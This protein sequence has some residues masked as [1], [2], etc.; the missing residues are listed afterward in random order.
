MSSEAGAAEWGDD[1][2]AGLL[3]HRTGAVRGF[4]TEG[5]SLPVSN[6]I[7]FH[8]ASS[9][10]FDGFQSG[11]EC[12]ARNAVF[13]MLFENSEAGDSPNF[14]GAGIGREILIFA[15]VVDAWKLFPG[16]V[17]APADRFSTRVDENS[18][19]AHLVDELS[20]LPAIPHASFTPGR[21]P[22]A[23]RQRARALKMHALTKIPAVPLR[24]ERFKI[25]PR[26]R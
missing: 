22:L 24:E 15:T 2:E 8:E 4:V 25:V 10:A 16:P 7:S 9:L 21:Q 1:L 13:A 11:V 5:A 19:G 18:V 17:L 14:F 12:G 23:L 20:L 6:R 26:L 3:E